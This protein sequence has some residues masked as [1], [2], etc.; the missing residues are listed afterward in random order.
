MAVPSLN[1]GGWYDLF[2]GGTLDNYTGMRD[3]APA[4]LIVGPWAHWVNEPQTEAELA[5]WLRAILANTLAT[6][7]RRF[8]AEARDLIRER[9]LHNF[10][11]ESSARIDS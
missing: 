9:P 7:A 1:L 10:M 4:S 2:L 3:H 5:G 11:A 8:A 6:A